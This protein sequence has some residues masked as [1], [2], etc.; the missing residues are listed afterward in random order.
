LK[1]ILLLHRYVGAAIGLVLTLW[2]LSGFV[3]MYRGFPELTAQD[4]LAGLQPLD[5][6]GWRRDAPSPAALGPAD[7]LRIEMLAGRPVMRIGAAG[8]ERSLDLRRGQAVG[9]LTPAAALATAKTYAAGHALNGAPRSLELIDVDQWTVEGAAA[10]GPV[11]RIGLS[12]P[13]R[14]TVYVARRSGEV[15]Q[16]T[17]R[18]GRFWGWV[19]AV[20]H[21]LY[22]TLLRRHTQVWVAVVIWAALA[23][24]FLT[25]TGLYV[26]IARFRRYASGRWSPYRGWHYWHHIVSLGFGVLTLTW[27]MSGL[28]SVNPWGLFET[29]VGEAEQASLRG[30]VGG[31][32]LNRFLETAPGLARG[33]VVALEAAPLGGRL[34]VLERFA[35]GRVIRLDAS[36]APA[37]L[38]RSE[39]ARALSRL[40]GAPVVELTRLDREDAYYYAGFGHAAPLPA[41]RASTSGPERRT[42]YLDA[43]SGEMTLALDSTARAG[44]WIRTGLHD[45][46]FPGLRARPL[47]DVVVLMLLAGVTFGCATGAWIGV[48]RLAHD[49]GRLRRLLRSRS[50]GNA[51]ASRS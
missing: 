15:V 12:D 44:R 51:Q 18:S 39:V 7:A 1:I 17:T 24:C 25:V 13:Q 8:G 33:G 37:P 43:V 20:P 26:G 3:M 19:G 40:G 32:E 49:F 10:R 16:A 29:S 11:Y 4:R 27:V 47:W 42:Y 2:C 48:K 36:G 34:F 9:D 30:A 45:F 50:A 46:D 22:P 35:D 23:G 28:F 14:T 38:R 41:W 5:L 21:W 31:A 6:T